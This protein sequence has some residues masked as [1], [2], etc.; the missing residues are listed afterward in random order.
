M[1]AITHTYTHTHTHTHTQTDG[2]EVGQTNMTK[3]IFNFRNFANAPEN[4]LLPDIPLD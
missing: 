2:R 3:L 4:Y 1:Q